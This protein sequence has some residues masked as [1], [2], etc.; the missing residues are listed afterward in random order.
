ML[1]SGVPELLT[2]QINLPCSSGL[3]DCSTN[4]VFVADVGSG[5]R[6]ASSLRITSTRR[7]HIFR[8]CVIAS[9]SSEKSGVS[10]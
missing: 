3:F 8:L 9:E 4:C 2:L 10:T 6:S 1:L 5:R 7:I